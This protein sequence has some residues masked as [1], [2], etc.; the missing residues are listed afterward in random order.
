MFDEK[1]YKNTFSKIETKATISV[2][3]ESEQKPKRKFGKRMVIIFAVLLC[4]LIGISSAVAEVIRSN[5]VDFK[6]LPMSDEQ[7]P[8]PEPREGELDY[9]A[10]PIIG[11]VGSAEYEAYI[12]WH[13]FENSVNFMENDTEEEHYAKY[14][15]LDALNKM[16]DA[17]QAEIA[18][19]YGLK[20]PNYGDGQYPLKMGKELRSEIGIDKFFD[21]KISIYDAG[22]YG[23]SEIQYNVMM[24]EIT[25]DS[26]YKV[27]ASLQDNK[28]GWLI[29]TNTYNFFE[30]LEN[31]EQ[32]SYTT[33]SG[34]VINM[35]LGNTRALI[36]CDFPNDYIVITV[37]P[38]DDAT[39]MMSLQAS[40]KEFGEKMDR[41][42]L[43]EVAKMINFDELY[44][45]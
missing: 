27:C 17:K 4:L 3:K 39:G 36:A 15:G 7:F 13:E 38:I 28:K 32:W 5:Y 35:N 26:G 6:A 44:N 12:E 43:E 24:S 45:Q 16:R 25:L 33:E 41:A 30:S 21:E 23:N 42:A 1:L 29:L 40:E 14:G 31:S 9:K 11:N 10:T 22:T 8:L 34:L 20:L 19:K 18:A 37:Y 2:P